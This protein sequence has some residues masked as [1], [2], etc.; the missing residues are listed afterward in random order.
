MVK[1]G[2]CLRG[3]GDLPVARTVCP[4]VWQA[5]SGLSSA[6]SDTFTKR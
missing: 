1:D 6:N 4:R 5:V 2:D 3:T